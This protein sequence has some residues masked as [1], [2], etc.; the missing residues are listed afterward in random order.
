[1]ILY[2]AKV[3]GRKNIPK[4]GGAIEICNHKRMFDPV[5]IALYQWRRPRFLAKKSIFKNFIMRGILKALGAVPIDRKNVNIS[6]M[7]RAVKIIKDG[8][9]MLMFPE[10]TRNKIDDGNMQEFKNGVSTFALMAKVPI[11]PMYILKKIRIFRFNRIFIGEPII[12]SEFYNTRPTSDILEKTGKIVT[13]KM[14]ELKDFALSY[15][16]KKKEPI[17]ASN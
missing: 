17:M 1:M 8:E 9:I 13:D 3:I 10:G 11:I 12:L 16:K 6:E 7:K 15:K 5:L 14:N 2:P 4:K